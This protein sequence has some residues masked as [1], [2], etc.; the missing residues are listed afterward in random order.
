ML[1]RSVLFVLMR[2]WLEKCLGL[3]IFSLRLRLGIGLGFTTVTEFKAR[4]KVY[5]GLV[6]RGYFQESVL[7]FHRRDDREEKMNKK[8]VYRGIMHYMSGKVSNSA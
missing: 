2:I 6:Y 3:D 8:Q 7:P 4:N 5:R 1:N